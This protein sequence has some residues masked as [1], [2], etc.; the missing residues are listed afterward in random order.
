MTASTSTETTIY[1]RLSDFRDDSDGFAGREA[2]LRAEADRLGWHVRNVVIENDVTPARN[3]RARPASAFKRRKMVTPSGRTEMRVDRPG[4]RAILG[5]LASGAIG[6]MLCEDLDRAAR[7]PRDLED[8]LDAVAIHRASARSLSGSLTLTD[9]GTDSEITMA[10]IMTAMANKASRDNARRVSAKRGDL[11]GQGWY[12][13]GRRPFGYV[14]DPNST[15]YHRTLSRVESEAA[16]IRGAYDAIMSDPDASASLKSIA[17][18]WRAAGV[19]TVTGA[20]WTAESVRDAITKPAVA[21]LAVTRTG[22]VGARWPGILT[23]EEWD[24]L[25]DVLDRRGAAHGYHGNAPTHLLSGIARCHCGAPVKASGG[26]D[27]APAYT[28][29]ASAHLRRNAAASDEYVLAFTAAALDR[30]PDLLRPPARPGVDLAALR[31]E[32]ARLTAMGERM[33]AMWTDGDL[34]DEEYRAGARQ[35]KD[36][37]D[38]I[39]GQLSAASTVDPLAPFRSAADA[40]AV[41]ASLPIERQRAVVRS[42]ASV[43]MLPATRRGSGFDPGSVEVTPAAA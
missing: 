11:S 9:G 43:T 36:R 2:R 8:L 40:A 18:N 15:K 38:A 19:P 20:A 35:R 5:D 21:G 32:A 30:D 27:R 14:P 10:R 12:G 4:F 16:A 7:D 23:R 41:L 37:L 26:R 31:A 22:F 42:V 39:A 34:T 33:T 29:T 3:G 13:G 17:R 25:R 6:A 24:G 28:C 1:L